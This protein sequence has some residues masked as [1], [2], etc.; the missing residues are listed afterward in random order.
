[1]RIGDEVA[2]GVIERTLIRLR[3]TLHGKIAGGAL[4]RFSTIGLPEQ[5]AY[6]VQDRFIRDLL[7]AVPPSDLSFF[8]GDGSR[9][10]SVAV[11]SR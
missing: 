3:L 5:F 2:T 10:T 9:S 11:L 6:P 4:I 7:N 8:I 1:M